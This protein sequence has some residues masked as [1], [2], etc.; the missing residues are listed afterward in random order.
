MALKMFPRIASRMIFAGVGSNSSI[1]RFTGEIQFV[2][3]KT[4]IRSL[5]LIPVVVMLSVFAAPSSGSVAAS[6][7]CPNPIFAPVLA[8]LRAGTRAPLRLPLLLG[9]AD[10]AALYARIGRISPTRYLIHIGQNCERSYCPYG[11]V[12]GTKL[13]KRRLCPRGKVVEFIGGVTGYLT[14]GSKILKN[15]VITWDQGWY[16]Y[17]IAIYAAEP[18]VMTKVANS[19]LSCASR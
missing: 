18:E 5:A 14:D 17:A 11:T 15:S 10:D 9:D 16:R 7:T 2:N 12:S 8:S 6:D 19:A 3:K 13:F 4:M 1:Q